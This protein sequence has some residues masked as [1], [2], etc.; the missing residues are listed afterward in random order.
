MG[1]AR[2]K[3]VGQSTGRKAAIRPPVQP[4]GERR[5]EALLA[6]ATAVFLERGFAGS[7]LDEVIARAGGSRATLYQQFGGKEGLFAAIIG[8]VCEHMVVPLLEATQ[9]PGDPRRV[10]TTFA[11][12]FLDALLA[13]DSLALY[14]VMSGE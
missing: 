9:S 5:R 12:R 6:A 8:A 4:R 10:L 14:R 7:T 2:Q 11:K 13:P 1:A 3:P